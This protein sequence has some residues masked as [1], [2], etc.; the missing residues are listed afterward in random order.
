MK[1][2]RFLD[3]LGQVG[4]K[5]FY[6]TKVSEASHASQESQESLESY[7]YCFIISSTAFQRTQ[8]AKLMLRLGFSNSKKQVLQIVS[9]T[10]LG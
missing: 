10:A 6:D 3:F 2:L 4:Q 8:N 5:S 7:K 1:L 9:S